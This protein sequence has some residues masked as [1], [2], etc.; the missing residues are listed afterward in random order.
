MLKHVYMYSHVDIDSPDKYRD[1][2]YS[3]LE[4]WNAWLSAG[5]EHHE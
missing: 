1:L 5:D 3:V 4:D 2:L